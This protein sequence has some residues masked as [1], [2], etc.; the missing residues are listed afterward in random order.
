MDT[1]GTL[2]EVAHVGSTPEQADPPLDN[3]F[4]NSQA[5]GTILVPKTNQYR[6]LE[7]PSYPNL[8]TNITE[9]LMTY[10]DLNLWTGEASEKTEFVDGLV[11]RDYIE[12][13]IL[14]NKGEKNVSVEFSS[15]IEDVERIITD[16]GHHYKLTV[17][18]SSNDSHDIWYQRNFDAVVVATGHYHVP[19]IPEVPGL[20]EAQEKFPGLVR[21][22]KYF[23]TAE[24]YKDKK[25]VVVGTRASGMDITRLLIGNASEVYHSRRNSQAP[26]LKN[27]VPK[28]VIRECKI[29]E[30]QVVVVF[31]DNSEVVA[32]DHIIYGTG[33]QFSYPFLNRLFAADNQVLTQDGVLVPGLYQHTFLINDPLIT[34][35]GVPIDGISF[36]VFEYQA[37]LVA[38]Y[39]AGRITLPSVL[40]QERWRSER[41]SKKG[42]SRS[43]HTIGADDALE[44]LWELARL[45]YL[46]K[47][48]VVGRPFPEF[49]KEDLAKYLNARDRLRAFWDTV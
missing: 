20:R 16:N 5:K 27:V 35:V 45:G 36:R 22:A 17:R 11:V 46:E 39:L 33:Y 49:T 12:A 14:R 21:H 47:S 30:N 2:T 24:P 41:F 32:P 29:V 10:S 31:D 18:Q 1:P 34:F 23:R 44:Y 25:V 6:Y 28:G 15:T 13:Y 40:E 48:S 7:T 3:P 19:F 4:R 42:P 26:V 38:R 37:I 9:L 8:K 43:Y